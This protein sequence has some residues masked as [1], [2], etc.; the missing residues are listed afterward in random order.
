[1]TIAGNAP[2]KKKFEG[3]KETFEKSALWEKRE[4]LPFFS[5]DPS[6]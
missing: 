6:K 4:D 5:L 2:K 1:M 3:K